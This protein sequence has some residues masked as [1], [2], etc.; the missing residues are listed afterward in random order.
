[1]ANVYKLYK[2]VCELE[3]QSMSRL[4]EDRL[5]LILN[6]YI[7]SLDLAQSK[8]LKQSRYKIYKELSKSKWMQS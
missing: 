8:L 3:P 4:V 1:M 6:N 5:N 2:E 7:E